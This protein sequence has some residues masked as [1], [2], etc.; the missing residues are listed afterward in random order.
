MQRYK[1]YDSFIKISQYS[2]IRINLLKFQ[3]YVVYLVGLGVLLFEI[4]IVNVTLY[5]S[6]KQR[7]RLTGIWRNNSLYDPT[8]PNFEEHIQNRA[9]GGTKSRTNWV[10]P[11]TF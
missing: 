1:L 7:P 3:I 5:A 6:V 9:L 8:N 2:K 11:I 4:W 10:S